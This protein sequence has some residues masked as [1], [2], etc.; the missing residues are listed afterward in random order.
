MVIV[1]IAYKKDR[2]GM[3]MLFVPQK[4]S[5]SYSS[6][7]QHSSFAWS[8]EDHS[9]LIIGLGVLVVLALSLL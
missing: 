3:N 5:G 7:M 2:G 4:E 8:A 1:G 9:F 6:R